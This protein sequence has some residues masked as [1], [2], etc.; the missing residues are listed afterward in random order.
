MQDSKSS[1]LIVGEHLGS[2]SRVIDVSAIDHQDD[3]IRWCVED[4]LK[5]ATR[6]LRRGNTYDLIVMD[7]P[8]WGLGPKGEKWKLEDQIG[9]LISA[10]AQ[11]VSPG[12][13][14]VMNTYSRLSP[15]SLENLWRTVLPEAR[16]EVGE[17]CLESGTG[18]VLPTGSLL[19]LERP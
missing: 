7:P 8:S 16:M 6:E 2:H 18:K 10:T 12:G 11:L 3:G 14:L 15:S 13:S 5:F 1:R 4:A 17:L 19:R 9:Q